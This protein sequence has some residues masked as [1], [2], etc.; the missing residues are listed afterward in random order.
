MRTLFG[1]LAVLA[2]IYVLLGAM[3]YL[4]QGSMVYLANLPGRT[5]DATPA[6][7]GLDYQDVNIDT[8]DGERLHGW[9]VP[10]A[11]P[12]MGEAR[13]VL[14]FF[15]GNAGNISHRLESIALFNRLGLDVL[16]VDYRG[17]GRS[18][19]KPTEAGTYRDARAAWDYLVGERGIRPGRIVVFGRSLGG[20]VGAWLGSQLP[21]AETPAAL[22]IESSFTSGADMARR[23]YPIFPAG[24]LTRLKYPVVDYAARL[25]CPVLVVHSRDDEI[26]P[27]AMGRAIYDAAPSP[28]FF[29]ELRGDH[30]AG[31]WISRASYT[32][33]LEAFLLEVL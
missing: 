6:D 25:N 18:T 30:N 3:L 2:G 11:R 14:L 19:G 5:L 1:L 32:A 7:A 22:I 27:Y 8:A 33:G 12:G 9:Y 26:I 28:R 31:F 20:A 4:L 17:Y 15:H 24:L 23:L 16:I 13:G 21:A 29:L 10:A